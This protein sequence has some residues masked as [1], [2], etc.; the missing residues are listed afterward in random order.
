MLHLL[1]SIYSKG[2]Y[3]EADTWTAYPGSK[4]KSTAALNPVLRTTAKLFRDRYVSNHLV[5]HG[6]AI[7]S[8]VT[9]AA[10][11]KVGFLN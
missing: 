4:E 6:T 2:L 3:R 8:D 7:D 9:Q 11:G 5:R 10:G 1:G